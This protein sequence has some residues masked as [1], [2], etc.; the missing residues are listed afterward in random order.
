MN[1]SKNL[2]IPFLF[3]FAISL[4][5]VGCD[6]NDDDGGDLD[7]FLGDWQQVEDDPEADLFLRVEQNAV[8]VAGVST[9]LPGFAICTVLTVDEFDINNGVIT[10][11]E[12]GEAFQSTISLNGNQLVVDG[13]TYSRTSDFP[14]CTATL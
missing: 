3:V 9:E 1:F 8:T 4:V 11:E 12:D 13:D 2:I 5:S 14:T 6:S 7:S 10:G